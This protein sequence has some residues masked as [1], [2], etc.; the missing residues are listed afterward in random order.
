[1]F[2][3]IAW[4]GG[5]RAID[6]FEQGD[7]LAGAIPWPTWPAFA[8][9]PFGAG[10]LALRLALDCL[11]HLAS[12]ATGRDLVPLRRHAPHGEERFE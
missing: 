11:G 2:C 9:V 8:L 5:L 6:S 7:V 12:L 4:V 3:L 10:L 1:M